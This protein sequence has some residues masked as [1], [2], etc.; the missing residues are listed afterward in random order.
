[1]QFSMWVTLAE[2]NLGASLQHM[3]IGFEQGFDKSVKEMFN[4]AASYELV[5]QMP[6][7]SIEGTPGEKE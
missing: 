6:F 1:M 2:L 3:N 7:G 5:A 4:L